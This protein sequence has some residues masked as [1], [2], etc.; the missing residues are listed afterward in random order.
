MPC[1][2]FT[3]FFFFFWR[4]HF[5]EVLDVLLSYSLTKKNDVIP[6]Y[7]IWIS[8]GMDDVN[9]DVNRNKDIYSCF[10]ADKYKH[11]QFN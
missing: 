2:N 10:Q 3:W 7:N 9:Y 4:T 5:K 11:R 8:V 6:K 1:G